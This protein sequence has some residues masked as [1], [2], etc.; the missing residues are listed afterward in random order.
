L[1]GL[2]GLN[3][4]KRTGK[5]SFGWEKGIKGGIKEDKYRDWTRWLQG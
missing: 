1:W 5:D 4:K 3:G 2:K